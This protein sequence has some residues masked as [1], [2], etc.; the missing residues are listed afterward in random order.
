M[1]EIDNFLSC[2][3]LYFTGGQSEKGETYAF[4]KR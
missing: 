4:G 2:I 3:R 1:K